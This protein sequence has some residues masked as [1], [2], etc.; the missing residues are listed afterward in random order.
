MCVILGRYHVHCI[1]YHISLVKWVSQMVVR[2]LKYGLNLM[3]DD[4]LSAKS[5]NISKNVKK[6][7]G[8]KFMLN[9]SNN[10]I[11]YFC[12]LSYQ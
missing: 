10:I 6:I 12:K 9:L 2:N 1:L 4:Q 3:C 11:Y 5:D 7:L 8:D